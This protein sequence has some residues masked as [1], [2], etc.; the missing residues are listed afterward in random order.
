MHSRFNT[1]KKSRVP[2]N[3]KERERTSKW[4]SDPTNHAGSHAG[5]RRG[6]GEGESPCTTYTVCF[7]YYTKFTPLSID[8]PHHENGAFKFLMFSG[9]KTTI[10]PFDLW[11]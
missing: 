8:D 9:R 7:T 4:K 10:R 11:M 2:I 1:G 5:P 3:H 6:G